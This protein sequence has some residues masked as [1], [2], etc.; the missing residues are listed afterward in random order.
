MLMEINVHFSFKAVTFYC[1]IYVVGKKELLLIFGGWVYIVFD[2]V[3]SK[4]KNMVIILY[5]FN[6]QN[7]TWLS[8]QTSTTYGFIMELPFN[9][10]EKHTII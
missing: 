3:I 10:M 7:T 4:H 1:N 2:Y 6:E 8:I 9:Y 5:N